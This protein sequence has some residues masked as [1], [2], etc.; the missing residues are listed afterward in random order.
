MVSLVLALLH[1]VIYKAISSIF[2]L[3]DTWR[4]VTGISLII[5]GLSFIAASAL[6]FFF[7]NPFTG[8]YY[9]VAA[10]WLGVATYLFLASCLYAIALIIVRYFVTTGSEMYV[11]YFGMMLV[12]VALALSIYGLIHA[13][14]IKVKTVN[15]SLPQM[16][17]SWVGK[18]AVW[19]SDIHQGAVYSLDFAK[20]IAGRVAELKPDII[21]IGGD[22]YD[23]TKVDETAVIKPFAD[24]HP[25]LGT[26]FIT[27]NHEEFGNN[28]HFLT[29][30]K[31]A[32]ITVLNDEMVNI[33]GLQLIGVDD[34]DSINSTKFQ[35]IISSFSIDKSLPSILLKHQPSQLDIASQAGITMQ[36]SGHTHKA[37]IWPLS[38]FT[39]LIFKG[40]DYGLNK[41]GDMIVYTSS[42]VGT[43]G[44][45]MRVGSDSE[46]VVFDFN[47]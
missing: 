5:L 30:V 12:A 19:I 28:A 29:A 27:G 34:R 41:W 1:F 37:Q 36:I 25:G 8:I 43:W 40:Y 35:S 7:D 10:S 13:R 46:I 31:S 15:V 18:R 22:F 6:A 45:P 20:E 24:L 21:F 4:F 3:S 14:S 23:G 9:T 47:K 17:A 33:Q 11:N 32:G 42:G 16:P 39:H 38:I 44:P 2:A 26:Y